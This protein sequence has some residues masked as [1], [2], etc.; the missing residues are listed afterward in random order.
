MTGN[1][2]AEVHWGG[3][4]DAVRALRGGLVKANEQPDSTAAVVSAMVRAMRRRMQRSMITRAARRRDD[5]E[6]WFRAD[7]GCGTHLA[8]ASLL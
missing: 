7:R 3:A 5:R 8:L 2:I 6:R 1:V 4:G